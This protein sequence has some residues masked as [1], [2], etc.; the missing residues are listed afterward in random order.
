MKIKIKNK[1]LGIFFLLFTLLGA[2]CQ[3][4]GIVLEQ[5]N[6]EYWGTHDSEVAIIP[7]IEEYKKTRPNV[8]IN[9][10]KFEE[11]DYEN[12]LL[13]ALAEDRGPDIFS[14]PNTSLQMY[15]SKISPLEKELTVGKIDENGVTYLKPEKTLTL[16]KVKNDYLD[17]ISET[18]ILPYESLD[19][20]G[21]SKNVEDRIFGMPLYMD[22]LVMYYNKDIFEKAGFTEAPKTWFAFVDVIKAI[23]KKSEDGKI[24]QSGAGI[25][26]G[27]NVNYHFDLLSVM[28]MQ[29]GAIMATQYGNIMFPSIPKGTDFDEPP[30]ISALRFYTDFAS[31]FKEGYT[32]NEKMPNSM[33]AFIQGKTAI[34]FGYVDDFDKIKEKAPKLNFSPA[35][36]PQI[37]GNKI[38]NIGR[39]NLE[40]VSKKSKNQNY[41]WDFIKFA[42][43]FE[44]LKGYLELTKKPTPFRVLIVEQ[45]KDE[46]LSVFAEQLL[47]A[48]SWYKGYNYSQ[49]S[50]SFAKMIEDIHKAK[51]EYMIDA[52]N[53]SAGEIANN[54]FKKD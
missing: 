13:N 36:M 22:T 38:R 51:Y 31:V 20:N 25:G 2:S 24:L 29:S 1:L 30:A 39:F 11:N 48:E 47:S 23:T 41:A 16:K 32:W 18:I 49:A 43:S 8:N 14:I 10:R 44:N 7:I 42:T 33:T 3:K 45:Q 53:A 40:V 5:V 54:Y 12:Y 9:Y 27:N 50:N 15:K 19:E 4:Q 52:I 26:T 28:M 35:K 34:Y 46:K 37:Q 21:Y 6:L 17:V